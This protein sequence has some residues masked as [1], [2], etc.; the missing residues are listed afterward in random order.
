[1]MYYLVQN[2][3]VSR[4][5]FRSA[6]QYTLD[7][8]GELPLDVVWTPGRLWLPYSEWSEDLIRR[9]FARLRQIGYDPLRDVQVSRWVDPARY[10]RQIG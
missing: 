6:V 8:S 2:R 3:S 1:M 4:F 10:L 7:Q 9:L 5:N